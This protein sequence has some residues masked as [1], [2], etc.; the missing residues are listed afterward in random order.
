VQS[1]YGYFQ[2]FMKALI[3]VMPKKT[4]LDPQGEAVRQAIQHLGMETVKAARVG[5]WI[6]LEI[7]GGDAEAA[8][9][10]LDVLCQDLLSNP[11][12]EDYELQVIP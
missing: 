8:R 11:V 1:N 2:A 5:K 4:V 10:K 12:V 7:E 3:K 9:K 6:E